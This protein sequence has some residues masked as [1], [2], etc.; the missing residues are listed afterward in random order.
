MGKGKILFVV[1]DEKRG[2][3]RQK[4]KGKNKFFK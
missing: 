1:D 4:S 2:G 3:G